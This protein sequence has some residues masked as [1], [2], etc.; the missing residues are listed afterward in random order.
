MTNDNSQTS[1]VETVRSVIVTHQKPDLDAV[2]SVWLLKRFLTS[3]WGTAIV[4]FVPSG[5][6]LDSTRQAE[7]GVPDDQVIHVDTGLGEFD[8]HQE[9]RGS[10]RVCATSLVFDHLT[11]FQVDKKKNQALLY[12]VEYV[13]QIDHFEDCYWP[14]AANLRYQLSIHN[15]LEGAVQTGLYDDD[16]LVQFGFELL[17]AAYAKLRSEV[18]A[19]EIIQKKGQHFKLG[20][21]NCLAI[22]SS[23]KDVEKRAQKLGTDL[24]IRK[25]EAS[26]H[27]RI[28]A[29]PRSN[30]DLTPVYEEI[31][32]KDSIGNWFLHASK[33]MLLNGSPKSNQAPT[34]L[35]LV[36]VVKLVKLVLA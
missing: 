21:Y 36:E 23:S 16:R 35:S 19:D 15:L 28:K 8:H 1:Q 27:V 24:V 10:E 20:K 30:I 32:E 31:L 14:E 11:T 3:K 12:L 9:D 7:L 34:P 4:E 26:G 29:T 33:R 25:D 13:T 18:K 22:A 2:T 6:R 5:S 17:D